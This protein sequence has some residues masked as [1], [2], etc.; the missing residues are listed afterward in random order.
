MKRRIDKIAENMD[1][2]LFKIM[3]NNLFSIQIDESI[4]QEINGYFWYQ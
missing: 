1:K 2:N 4:L 3:C